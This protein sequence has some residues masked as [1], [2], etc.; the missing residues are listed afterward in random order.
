MGVQSEGCPKDL[1]K[2]GSAYW[3]LSANLTDG[4]NGTGIDKLTRRVGGGILTNTSLKDTVV[5]VSYNASCC[6]PRVELVAVDMMGNVKTLTHTVDL[7]GSSIVELAR[8]LMWLCLLIGTL[9][10]RT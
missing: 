2:C 6:S 4:V 9:L 7:N 3:D 5:M 8:P 10:S 1:T